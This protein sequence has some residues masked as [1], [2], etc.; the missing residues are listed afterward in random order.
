[1]IVDDEPAIRFGI[2]NA[3]NWLSLQCTII[4]SCAEG[5]EALQ[6]AQTLMPDIIITDIMM[7]GLTGLDLI[8]EIRKTRQDTRFIILSGYDDFTY[9]KQAISLDVEDFLLK[10]LSKTELSKAV[11]K[12]IKK[13]REYKKNE[14]L[15][16]QDLRQAARLLFLRQLARGEIKNDE[17]FEASTI[18]FGLFTNHSPFTI[19]IFQ[20]PPREGIP[21]SAS[22]SF[23]EMAHSCKADIWEQDEHLSLALLS[24][25]HTQAKHIAQR[26]YET[27]QESNGNIAIGIGDSVSQSTEIPKSFQ[28]ALLAVSYRIFHSTKKIFDETDIIATQ[29]HFLSYDVD[30]SELTNALFY[31]TDDDIKKRVSAFFQRLLYIPTP[32]PSYLK[33][34]C[35]YLISDT[36]KNLVKKQ[37]VSPELMPNFDYVEVNQLLSL[38]EIE[39]WV[40]ATLLNIKDVVIPRS[41]IIND[42]IIFQAKKIIEDNITPNITAQEIANRLNINYAYFSTYFKEKTGQNFRTYLNDQKNL[43]AKELLNDD[44]LS[45]EDIA[46]SLGYTDYRSFWRNFK[47]ANGLTPSEYRNQIKKEEHH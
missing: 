26:F 24:C 10:P 34:M 43:H 16:G 13:L 28:K 33:G 23:S 40:C 29:P 1:M 20:Y 44:Q 11:L 45:I 21:L 9:A 7:P 31:G 14:A 18:K 12:S 5:H 15:S 30:T 3:I 4:A 39:E 35:V 37:H 41:R 27:I 2:K 25:D 8:R 47:N 6:L 22:P 46:R 19:I 42:P 36:I 32:P 17:E 38:S